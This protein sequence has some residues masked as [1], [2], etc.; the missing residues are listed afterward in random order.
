M[1][2]ANR[3]PSVFADPDSLDVTRIPRKHLALGFGAHKCLGQHLARTTLTIGLRALFERFPKLRLATPADEVP[4]RDPRRGR[5]R[6]SAP[7]EPVERRRRVSRAGVRQA[8]PENRA[9]TPEA[10]RSSSL[11]PHP[12]DKRS[13]LERRVEHAL[14]V[15]PSPSRV[16]MS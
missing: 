2:A 5:R 3:D 11:C 8:P 10:L 6:P 16:G 13:P 1:P 9:P 7:W 12:G 14:N 4:L 15:R